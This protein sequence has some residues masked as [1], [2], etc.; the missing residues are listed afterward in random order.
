ME[1]QRSKLAEIATKLSKHQFSMKFQ[2]HKVKKFAFV[3]KKFIECRCER[4][5]GLV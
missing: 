5:K 3:V 4:R 1:N 2:I